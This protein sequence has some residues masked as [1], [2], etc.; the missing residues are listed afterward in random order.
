MNHILLQNINQ[1][2]GIGLF[3]TQEIIEKHLQGNMKAYNETYTFES[4]EYTV[5]V[6]EVIIPTDA[7]AN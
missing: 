4:K 5:A 7:G 1:G 3:M 2:T 6:F